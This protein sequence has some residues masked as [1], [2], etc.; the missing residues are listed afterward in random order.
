MKSDEVMPTLSVLQL[1]SSIG[2]FGA[3]SMIVELCKELPKFSC[4]PVIGVFQNQHNPHLELVDAAHRANVETVVFDCHG[5]ID[6]GTLR[7][8]RY[9]VAQRNIQIIHSHGYK[10]NMYAVLARPDKHVKLVS[11]CHPWLKT[12]WRLKAY[13]K[14]D[15]IFL[16]R[17]HQVIAVSEK[18]RQELLQLRL[19]A[20]I[21]SLI[22]NG[23]EVDRFVQ[24]FNL[25][26]MR[27]EWGITCDSIIIGTVGRLSPE[28]GHSVFIDVAKELCLSHANIVFLLIGDG[29]ML[30]KLK[31]RCEEYGIDKQVIFTG[32]R[33]DIPQFL[34]LMDIFVLPSLTEGMPMALLEAMA[35]GRPII[36][37][38]VG[39][40]PRAI[41]HEK[42]GTLIAPNRPDQLREAIL[43]YIRQPEKAQRH[44]QGARE[45]V[46]LEFSS[47]SMA[48]R[49]VELYTRA[50]IQN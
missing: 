22:D 35:A 29:P 20:K 4:H 14:L 9:Y 48:Q 42:S 40:I 30:G 11:T 45:K 18:E 26:G 31:K 37:T 21:V 46:M 17:F 33:T 16:S 36:A 41:D 43:T 5:Q 50:G 12:H 27:Q 32:V 3:E 19:N 25:N 23:I 2:F 15:K 47:R 6:F 49:Y 24:Q 38:N 28:K 13:E 8:I 10:A 7:K 44:A 34:A 39:D 1:R